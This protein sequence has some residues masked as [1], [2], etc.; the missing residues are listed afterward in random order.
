[1]PVPA[2]NQRLDDPRWNGSLAQGLPL[3]GSG[4]SGTGEAVLYRALYDTVGGV[5]NLYMSWL[6]KVDPTGPEASID[7]VY[8]GFSPGGGGASNTI[9]KVFLDTPSAATAASSPSPAYKVSV[10]SRAANGTETNVSTS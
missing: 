7:T 8:V 5:T 4:G 9:I 10:F 1:G 2:M 3:L 6:V